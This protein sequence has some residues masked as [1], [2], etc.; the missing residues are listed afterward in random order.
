MALI[1]AAALF[2]TVGQAQTVEWASSTGG[3]LADSCR[4]VAVDAVG[5]SY[6]TGYY[7]DTAT[8]GAFVLTSAGGRDAFVAKY[9]PAGNVVWARSASGTLN[10][11]GA[12]I[13]VDSAGNIYVSGDF[14]GTATFGPFVLTNA[15]EFNNFVAK[16]DP[17]GNVVWAR[18]A[19]G[20]LQTQN[21]G[22]AVDASGNSYVT[23]LF[24]GTAMF[25]SFV[26]TSAGSYDA[27]LAK[28]DA[29]GDVV[30]ARSDGGSSTDW[31]NGIA[32]DA[33]GNSYVTGRFSSTGTAT[34]DSFVLTGTGDDDIFVAKYDGSGNVVWARSGGG[35]LRDRGND[36]AVDAAGNSYV[37]ALFSGTATFGSFGLTSAGS[38]D[39][40]VV[41]YDPAGNVVW[42]RSAG[43]SALDRG[44]GIA[45]DV[46]GNSYVTGLHSGAT[47][48]PFVL[49]SA[50]G[51][52]IF[53]ARYDAAGNVVWAESAGGSISSDWGLGVAVDAD[54][55]SY[56]TGFYV[57]TATFGPFVL[58]A[59]AG[60]KDIYVV[61]Y[62][63]PPSG[64]PTVSEW[65]LIVMALLIVTAGTLVYMRRHPVAE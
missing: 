10:V 30:W 48:G 52:D 13:G 15:G 61:K 22:I 3:T 36:I 49:T 16:Y 29:A 9:D 1:L 6:A 8:F 47:F 33:A 19:G 28:Y 62:A 12:D 58:T 39:V 60:S 53:M 26:L 45:V 37:A 64:I 63:A 23:G 7:E 43:G 18:S 50:G 17:V 34:F 56:F 20:T 65:G 21:L 51:I 11:A 38:E 14:K 41:K 40:A 44:L 57:G 42:A 55:N 54:D 2:P 46:D 27:F 25:G 4:A 59:S 35:T 5:N 32:V 31:A 24:N